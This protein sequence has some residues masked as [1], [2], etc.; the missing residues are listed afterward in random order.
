MKKTTLIFVYPAPFDGEA[1]EKEAT[2]KVIHLGAYLREVGDPPERIFTSTHHSVIQTGILLGLGF[3]WNFPNEHPQGSFV[4]S[5]L[6]PFVSEMEY[7]NFVQEIIQLY[8]G[9]TIVLVCQE[10][11]IQ[12]LLKNFRRADLFSETQKFVFPAFI[13]TFDPHGEL[14]EVRLEGLL[15][16]VS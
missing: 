11:K 12:Q 7:N 6:D 5:S 9:E 1:V 8:R 4:K 3:S 13:F 10:D 15:K 14:K 2:R 16:G